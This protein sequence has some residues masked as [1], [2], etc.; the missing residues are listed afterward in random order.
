[1]LKRNAQR[2][3]TLVEIAIVL[4][5]IGLLLGGILKGQELIRSARVRNLAD[6]NSGIQG[7]YYG[8]VDRYRQVPGDMPAGNAP[9]GA[10]SVL[11]TNLLPNCA[12]VG[13]DGD[14]SLDTGAFNESA[15]AWAQMQAAGFIQGNYQGTAANA[16]NYVNLVNPQA[17]QNPW[18]GFMLLGRSAS[19]QN[20]AA[21]APVRLH[22]VLGNQ[23]PV[24]I[25]R[26]LDLKID[27]SFPLTGVL[28]ASPINGSAYAP[29]GDEG[30]GGSPP[31]TTAAGGVQIWDITNASVACNGYFLY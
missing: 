10:C 26:E 16:A 6:Q 5:I 12:A 23:V 7:A 28:R 19:Y 29:V 24:E 15:A 13:G 4:V 18:G 1:M 8:F 11:G 22:L 9:N 21:N 30:P 3:F 25:M 27:D 14:G 17:P 20:V 31:C 2:G